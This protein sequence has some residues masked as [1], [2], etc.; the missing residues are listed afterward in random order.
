M[1]AWT[2]N[3]LPKNN[4]CAQCGKLIPNPSWSEVDMNRIHFIWHC[5]ACEY[6]FQST[7]IYAAEIEQIAA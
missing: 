1:P 3:H 6:C 4:P 7:A 2:A 5:T